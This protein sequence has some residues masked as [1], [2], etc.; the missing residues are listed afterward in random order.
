MVVALPPAPDA[1]T[2]MP[3]I[4]ALILTF[5]MDLAAF[6][7]VPTL[8]ALVTTRLQLSTMVAAAATL[9]ESLVVDAGS[10]TEQDVLIPGLPHM[11][12]APVISTQQAAD[13]RLRVAQTPLH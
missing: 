11:T 5:M 6:L 10:P 9:A 7:V 2:V 1:W 13:T 8:L 3:S 12:L 4:S